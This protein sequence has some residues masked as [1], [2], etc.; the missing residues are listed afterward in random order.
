MV[1]RFGQSGVGPWHRRRFAT[2]FRVIDLLVGIEPDFPE[3]VER[4]PVHLPAVPGRFARDGDAGAFGLAQKFFQQL[5]RFKGISL[6]ILRLGKVISRCQTIPH[7]QRV[8]A[9]DAFENLGR[10]IRPAL[11]LHFFG[12]VPHQ[13]RIFQVGRRG[14][15]TKGAHGMCFHGIVRRQHR[16]KIQHDR[17]RRAGRRIEIKIFLILLGLLDQELAVIVH[18]PHL[19]DQLPATVDQDETRFALYIVQQRTPQFPG[20]LSLVIFKSRVEGFD[21]LNLFEQMFE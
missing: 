15:P 21:L 4:T 6:L 3:Q 2:A 7:R 9:A 20:G 12:Q 17:E 18:I 1:H 13:P 11:R 14:C 19:L 16:V 8:V 10:Q 5:Q